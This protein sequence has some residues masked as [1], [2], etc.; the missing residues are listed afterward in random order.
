MEKF[1]LTIELGETMHYPDDIARAIR[2]AA[3]HVQ[4]GTAT[5]KVRDQ[6]GNFVGSF[7]IVND[8]TTPAAPLHV[9]IMTTDDG[10]QLVADLPDWP[11]PIP[12]KGDYLFHPPFGTGDPEQIA[13]HVKTVGW[14]THDRTPDPTTGAFSQTTQPYVEIYI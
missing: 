14:R 12:H 13:G 2:S 3:D 7:D 1:T 5:G 9:R 11:Y 10:P 8:E 4:G 6:N